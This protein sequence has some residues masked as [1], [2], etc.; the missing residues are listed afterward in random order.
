MAAAVSRLRGGSS[1][2]PEAL[3]ETQSASEPAPAPEAPTRYVD[4][5]EVASEQPA[6]DDSNQENK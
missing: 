4:Y 2:A 1:P 6:A 5:G 3:P